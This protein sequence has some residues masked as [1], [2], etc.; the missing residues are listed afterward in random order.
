LWV[1]DKNF[2]PNYTQE[3]LTNDEFDVVKGIDLTQ[4]KIF[5]IKVFEAYV[6]K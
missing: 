6:R 5:K 3:F 4:P 1:E 2:T